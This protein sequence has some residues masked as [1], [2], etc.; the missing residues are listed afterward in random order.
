M[1]TWRKV[2]T[3]R[4]AWS[5]MALAAKTQLVTEWCHRLRERSRVSIFWF[6]AGSRE[7]LM[8]KYQQLAQLHRHFAKTNENARKF[9]KTHDVDGDDTALAKAWIK[10]YENWVVVLDNYDTISVD[11][12]PFLPDGFGRVVITSRDRRAIG[13]VSNRGFELKRPRSSEAELLFLRLSCPQKDITAENIS[14]YPEYTVVKEIVSDL[15]GFPLAISQAAAYVRENEPFSCAE[16]LEIL[17]SRSDREILLRFKEERPE[18]PESVMTTWEISLAY[19]KK[20]HPEA[21]ELLQLLGFFARSGV[22]EGILQDS[23]G[24]KP[25]R[26]GSHA[27]TRQLNNE[28][29]DE[30]AFLQSRARTTMSLGILISLSLVSKSYDKIVSVHPLVHEWI[31]ARLKPNPTESNRVLR[32]CSLILYQAF[33]LEGITSSHMSSFTDMPT[34]MPTFTP[35]LL[36]ML[37]VLQQTK[38]YLEPIPLELGTVLL[39]HLLFEVRRD[40]VYR[41]TDLPPLVVRAFPSDTS[42]AKEP[43]DAIQSHLFDEL[44]D[45]SSLWHAAALVRIMKVLQL[46]LSTYSSAPPWTP[47]RKVYMVALVTFALEMFEYLPHTESASGSGSVSLDSRLNG[48]YSE[49]EHYTA[50]TLYNIL[51]FLSL[52]TGKAPDEIS[53]LQVRVGLVLARIMTIDEYLKLPWHFFRDG[54]SWEQVACVDLPTALKY[55]AA[56]AK[57][58]SPYPKDATRAILLAAEAFRRFQQPNRLTAGTSVPF[59][60]NT[61]GRDIESYIPKTLDESMSKASRVLGDAC[62]E[63]GLGLLKGLELRTTTSPMD[64]RA[65]GISLLNLLRALDEVWSVLQDMMTQ[66]DGNNGNLFL[67]GSHKRRFEFQRLYVHAHFLRADYGDAIPGL[68]ELFQA[69]KVIA[70]FGSEYNNPRR[71]LLDHTGSGNGEDTVTKIPLLSY[72]FRPIQKDTLKHQIPSPGL[73]GFRHRGY[74]NNSSD[75]LDVGE[76]AAAWYAAGSRL[77]DLNVAKDLLRIWIDCLRHLGLADE[78]DRYTW[79]DEVDAIPRTHSA[80]TIVVVH[81]LAKSSLG[82]AG[83]FGAT[84]IPGAGGVSVV[85]GSG[86]QWQTTGGDFPLAGA[87]QESELELRDDFGTAKVRSTTPKGDSCEHGNDDVIFE[88][89]EFEIELE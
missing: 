28:Q 57:F 63:C 31:Q 14:E 39:V 8:S 13:T 87:D 59:L 53:F 42:V 2:E 71:L 47:S 26:V 74:F 68:Q 54:I 79:R 45:V 32:L 67:F 82:R 81:S 66:F 34:F 4:S 29:R 18:Y 30:L 6:T 5:F 43:L 89:M 83:V 37:D 40:V 50:L 80:E 11:V 52:E 3:C 1:L 78:R 70:R 69:E 38:H 21:A 33:P 19:L 75:G 49:A 72:L 86:S 7:E 61:F 77:E 9:V 64:E 88:D 84:S 85:S 58:S 62:L 22:A 48:P 46:G 25:W 41:T 36:E 16:Y 73:N 24:I 12:E 15:D 60:S 27:T 20:K 44:R 10:A 51:S 55:F 17:R 56:C 76:Q 65:A 35:H 23:T